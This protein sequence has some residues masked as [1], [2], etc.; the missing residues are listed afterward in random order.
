MLFQ[1]SKMFISAALEHNISHVMQ[2]NYNRS[3]NIKLTMHAC[4]VSSMNVHDSSTGWIC[5]HD[6]LAKPAHN[7]L[8]NAFKMSAYRIA[9]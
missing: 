3:I 6:L 2:Y 7:L 9:S 8:L 4:N 5:L 1:F